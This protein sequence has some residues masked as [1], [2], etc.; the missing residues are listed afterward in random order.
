MGQIRGQ[1]DPL[2]SQTYHPCY[3]LSLPVSLYWKLRNMGKCSTS[4]DWLD[5]IELNLWAS[6]FTKTGPN[7]H[8][9]GQILTLLLLAK[10]SLNVLNIYLLI[11]KNLRLVLFST[12][13]AQKKPDVAALNWN[14]PRSRNHFRWLARF[15][16]RPG[17]ATLWK[18]SWRAC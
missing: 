1:S 13:L 4:A 17:I 10:A 14:P 9:T 3:N 8:Q 16:P 11:Y 5:L 6:D 2:W 12:N 15:L 18:I 7:L